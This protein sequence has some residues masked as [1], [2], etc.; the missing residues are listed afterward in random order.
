[1]AE[2]AGQDVGRDPRHQVLAERTRRPGATS[3]S[4]VPSGM[5]SMSGLATTRMPRSVSAT[6][7]PRRLVWG[8]K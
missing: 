3:A 5:T 6:R 1:V 2:V 8:R 7:W 4:G